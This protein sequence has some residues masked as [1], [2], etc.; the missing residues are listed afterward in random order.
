MILL[1]DVVSYVSSN[2][3]SI[4]DGISIVSFRKLHFC[5]SVLFLGQYLVHFT[6]LC[7]CDHFFQQRSLYVLFFHW[8]MMLSFNILAPI[9]RE[10]RF[11]SRFWVLCLVLNRLPFLN[12][13]VRVWLS[14]FSCI[15]AHC[16]LKHLV[17]VA[18]SISMCFF[19]RPLLGGVL[20][21]SCASFVFLRG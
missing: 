12:G 8:R 18:P 9:C 3:L 15:Q 2:S 10:S 5:S 20:F 6:E 16:R 7:I 11:V 1:F 21:C 13:C 14:S 19:V 17:V 4:F